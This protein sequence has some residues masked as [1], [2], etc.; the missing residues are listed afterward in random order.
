VRGD[1]VHL[2]RVLLNLLLNGMDAV[3]E[4]AESDR[5][6]FVS[7][8]HNGDGFIEVSVKDN[9]RGIEPENLSRIFDSFFTTKPE[10]MGIGLSMARSIV[11]MH[12]GR[13]WAENNRDDKGTT[14][15][16]TLPVSTEPQLPPATEPA[17]EHPNGEAE[18][19]KKA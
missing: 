11:Q 18:I 6:L 3:K 19:S 16:F 17:A 9:G 1:A 5:H 2:Q 7:T 15:R 4:N 8:A 14:F 10:G 12:S 13:L